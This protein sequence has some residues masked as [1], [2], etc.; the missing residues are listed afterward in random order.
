M[1]LS[2]GRSAKGA[3]L[4]PWRR[5]SPLLKETH[6]AKSAASHVTAGVCLAV[7]VLNGE[8]IFSP[9]AVHL[10]V[11]PVFWVLISA[12]RS[13]PFLGCIRGGDFRI[14]DLHSFFHPA[15]VF[16]GSSSDIKYIPRMR[17]TTMR[18]GM[19]LTIFAA[20][21]FSFLFL[22]LAAE[23]SNGP[24]AYVSISDNSQYVTAR[25]CAAGCLWYQG[26]FA[27][28]V[29]RG[30]YDL[31]QELQCGCDAINN[32]YC[33]K[34][35]AASASSYISSCVSSGCSKFPGEQQSAI[36][37]YNSY[38]ATAN[39]ARAS[40][41]TTAAAAIAASVTAKTTTS[42]KATSTISRNRVIQTDSSS[43]PNSDSGNVVP[44]PTP[45]T[46]AITASLKTSS[47]TPRATSTGEAADDDKG[48]SKSDLIALGVGLGVGI[49][50]LCVAL[51]TFCLMRRKATRANRQPEQ[52]L[53]RSPMHRLESY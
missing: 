53:A 42:T 32:C 11:R 40:N 33:G 48:L 12:G 44:G 3:R 45:V 4:D 17:F 8:N 14:F 9:C 29:N 25:P 46:T 24:T 50:S 18:P 1:R 49:P 30:Y 27:C 13:P 2:Q 16:Q 39:V 15:I 5:I 38:C 28:G 26:D 7:V 36:A 22:A 6:Y 19:N 23:T 37:L 10:L 43:T 31:A 51:A 41:W 21:V 20:V 35:N 34:D 47:T 52:L